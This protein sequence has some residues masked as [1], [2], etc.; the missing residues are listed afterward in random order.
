MAEKLHHN[1]C[2]EEIAFKATVIQLHLQSAKHLSGKEQL[3]RNE[4]QEH[5]IAQQFATYNKQEHLHGETLPSATQVYH[6]KVVRTFLHAGVP[7]NKVDLFRELL[8]EGGI[9]LAGH[10]FLSDLVPF[11]QKQEV[12]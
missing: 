12:E 5:Y 7:L 9:C 10:K 4:V 11:I 8:E 2:R 6:M 1:A 3:Q